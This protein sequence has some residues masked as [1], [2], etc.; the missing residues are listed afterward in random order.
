MLISRIPDLEKDLEH[1]REIAT[2][3]FVLA[4][5]LGWAGPEFLHSEYPDRWRKIYE[6]RNYF[7]TDP[8]FFWT[9]RNTGHKRWSEVGYPD[10]RGINKKA[11]KFGLCFGAVFCQKAEGKKSFFSAG[12]PDREF[13]ET[14][15]EQ[16]EKYFLKWIQFVAERP[17]LTLGE[18]QTMK[19]LSEGLTQAQTAEALKVSESTVKKRAQS[20]MKKFKASTRAEAV[21]IAVEKRYFTLD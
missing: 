10:P 9:L 11:K 15:M 12:R 7:M 13:T 18:L 6:D 14:E 4:V 2:A 17:E 21:S 16:L 5:N 20:V 3:G 19:C 8:V 1:I